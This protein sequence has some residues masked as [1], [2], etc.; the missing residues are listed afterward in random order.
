MTTRCTSTRGAA[1][2]ST[3]A[4]P[5]PLGH[6]PPGATGSARNRGVGISVQPNAGGLDV[7]A[8]G[9]TLVVANNYNDS[10]SVIDTASRTRPLRARPAS[11][12]S[13]PTKDAPAAPGGTFPFAVVMKGNGIAYVSSDRDREVVALTCPRRR[14]GRLIKRIKLDGNALG[15]TL[16]ASESR[17]YVAQDN[18]DQVASSTPRR[19]RVVASIDARGTGRHAAAPA[20]HRRGHLRGDDLSG[21]RDAVCGEQRRRTRLPSS[22]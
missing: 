2:A 6:Y 14:A 4:A 15:M 17:L 21:R 9:K 16:D 20:L 19:N 5:I 3:A 1:A 8:D 11:V 13:P 18:A 12:S 7:S 22:R 10:I